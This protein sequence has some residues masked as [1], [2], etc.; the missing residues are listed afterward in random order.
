MRAWYLT[1]ILCACASTPTKKESPNDEPPQENS[2]PPRPVGSGGGSGKKELEDA[3]KLA[4]GG[5][6]DGAIKKTK[7]AIAKNPNNEEAYLLLGSA[8]AMKDDAACEKAAYE[9]GAKAL[10]SSAA[11]MN[12]LGLIELRAGNA[13]KAVEILEKAIQSNGKRDPKMMADLAYAYIFVNRLDD[14]EKL[15]SS[16]RELDPKSIEAAMSLG[17]VML[18]KK[19]GKRA[20]EAFTAALALTGDAEVKTNLTRQLA[21]SEA[22]AGK[23]E[24]ALGHYRAL[25]GAG[26]ENDPV[27]HAQIAGTLIA[28]NRAKE[29]V[30]EM[31]KAVK[32]APEDARF[33]SLLMQAQEKAGDKKAAAATKKKLEAKGEK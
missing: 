30:T 12:E 22:M 10:P 14:G 28:L 19:D 25:L 4:N 17:E 23:H 1:L 8:C 16:A 24:D 29:A 9:D 15:A 21:V 5:D 7:E 32:L 31:E 11:I 26:G 3:K 27:L 33:L 6:L 13:K 18:R 2:P 20:A